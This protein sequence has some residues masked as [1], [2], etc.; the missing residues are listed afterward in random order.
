MIYCIWLFPSQVCFLRR[1]FMKVYTTGQVAKICRRLKNA[2]VVAKLIDSGKIDG[3]SKPITWQ[4]CTYR[5][6]P[7]K[8]LIEF[9]QRSGIP[10]DRLDGDIAAQKWILCHKTA[11]FKKMIEKARKRSGVLSGFK[12]LSDALLDVMKNLD[13]L[14]NLSGV[15]EDRR[16]AQIFEKLVEAMKCHIRLRGLIATSKKK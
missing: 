11:E 9:M 10:F 3:H 15:S 13:P 7:L 12:G 14:D 16:R 4:R 1:K 6:V 8:S 2:R 5:I